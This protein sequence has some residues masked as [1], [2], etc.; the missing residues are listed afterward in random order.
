M[1]SVKKEFSFDAAH[2][3]LDYD[4]LCKNIH[5]HT[6]HYIIEVSGGLI[7]GMVLD[8]HAFKK[9]KDKI[10]V[11]WDHAILLNSKDKRFI[12]SLKGMRVYVMDG[13]PTAENMASLIYLWACEVL[14][15][16]TVI[17]VELFETPTCSAKV[18]HA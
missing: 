4:G 13:N 1:Y 12:K 15:K 10:D 8:F 5:G 6:Y 11:L 9:L 3:L 17:S 18:T 14:D 7:D 2:R 16:V